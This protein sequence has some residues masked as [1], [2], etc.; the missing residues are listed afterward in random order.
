MP[1]DSTRNLVPVGIMR[2]WLQPVR[3]AVL[4]GPV[5]DVYGKEHFAENDEVAMQFWGG[6]VTYVT[7]LWTNEF[8]S[9]RTNTVRIYEP[10]RMELD[11]SG[12]AG[13]R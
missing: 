10:E 8:A 6:G 3:T 4:A 13:D 12:E 7:K 5:T 9:A 11:F 2:G 1:E